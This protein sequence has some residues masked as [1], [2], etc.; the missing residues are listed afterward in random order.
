MEEE[1]IVGGSVVD[2][3]VR[4]RRTHGKGL[5]DTMVSVS[6]VALWQIV[7]AEL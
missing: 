5:L 6:L 3:V 4:R 7:A 1:F 2:E